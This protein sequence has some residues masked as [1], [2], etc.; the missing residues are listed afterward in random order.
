MPAAALPLR[1]RAVPLS[2][3][4]PSSGRLGPL[5]FLGGLALSAEDA[6]FGGLSG[7][8]LS[9]DGALLAVT[10]RGSW[11]R[12]RIVRDRGGMLT[13]LAETALLPIRDDRGR[14]L[15]QGR[16]TDAEAL[17]RL[18]DG[19]LLVAF[20]QVSRLRAFAAPDAPGLPFPGPPTAGLPR[21]EGLEALTVLADGR[22]LAIAEAVGEDGTAPAWLG[23]PDG[24]AWTPLRYRP[25]P[26]HA[27]VDAAGLPG[28]GALVLERRASLLAGFTCRIAHLPPAALAA[29]VLD[30]AAV[31]TLA[32]PVTS[33]N[34]EGI[35]VAA[36]PDGA[37]DL[38][39]VS[40]DNFRLFQRNILML[41]RLDPA[42][43]PSA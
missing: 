15:P 18:P 17:A 34:Y 31:A 2:E 30:A 12:A 3:E 36:R 1:T 32:P 39:L 11:F 7:L 29:P 42:A 22:I 26:G 24:G 33:D 21:N 9:P 13:G 38:A 20:E 28:G 4:D 16:L 10:D 25:G 43:L 27:P 8:L 6:G 19:R 37:L 41:F 23:R 35:A 5:A 14:P 40:D